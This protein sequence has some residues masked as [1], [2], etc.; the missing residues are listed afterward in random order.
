MCTFCSQRGISA[1]HLT[2]NPWYVQAVYYILHLALCTPILL[3][4]SIIMFSLGFKLQVFACLCEMAHTYVAALST[5]VQLLPLFRGHGMQ[6]LRSGFISAMYTRGQLNSDPALMVNTSTAVQVNRI[7]G[8]YR[9]HVSLIGCLHAPNYFYFY[10]IF[11]Q[12]V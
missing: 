9:I 6:R 11:F 7:T 3:T 10:F 1:I 8:Q 4:E 2:L 5:I 12:N